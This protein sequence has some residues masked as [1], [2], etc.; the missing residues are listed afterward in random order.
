MPVC[1][2]AH[3]R[4]VAPPITDLSGYACSSAPDFSKAITT[5]FDGKKEQTAEIDITANSACWNRK[6]G[7]ALYAAFA[8]PQIAAAY[9]VTVESDPMGDALLAP[10][11]FT[12]AEDGKLRRTFLADARVFRGN[13]MSVLFRSHPDERY[14]VV[15]SDPEVTGKTSS[16]VGE[17]FQADAMA[18]GGIYFTITSGADH[19]TTYTYTH[20][21]KISVTYSAV[22]S[23]N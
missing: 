8:L 20:S 11:V 22:P 21:G 3:N 13:R 17:T 12:F 2:R 16:R 7:S 1:A 4:P 14:I 9:I 6:D 15:S 5:A 10:C 18:G 19:T 23:A